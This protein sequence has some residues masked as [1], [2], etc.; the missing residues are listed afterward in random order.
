MMII[1][2]PITSWRRRGISSYRIVT[3]LNEEHVTINHNR[4]SHQHHSIIGC[5]GKLWQNRNSFS[6]SLGHTTNKYL[7]RYIKAP[8]ARDATP[9]S[10]RT[11]NFL[12]FSPSL[13][14]ALGKVCKIWNGFIFHRNYEPKQFLATT[15]VQCSPECGFLIGLSQIISFSSLYI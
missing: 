2:I 10:R 3:I 5:A 6:H 9:S 14:L 7:I 15:S 13:L 1:I 4:H 11:R 12:S 8:T